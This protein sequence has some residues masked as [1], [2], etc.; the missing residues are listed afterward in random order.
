MKPPF[1]AWWNYLLKS[2]LIVNT[3]WNKSI[4][5]CLRKFRLSALPLKSITY[6]VRVWWWKWLI[7][8]R[9]PRSEYADYDDINSDGYWGKHMCDTNFMWKCSFKVSYVVLLVFFKFLFGFNGGKHFLSEFTS[10]G[11]KKKQHKLIS[12]EWGTKRG[13]CRK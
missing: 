11:D 13:N 2:S 9:V 7:I 6:L 12:M 3:S 1:D 4:S 5:A 10:F 8:F